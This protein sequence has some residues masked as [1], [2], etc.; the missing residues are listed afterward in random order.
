MNY[1][2]TSRIITLVASIIITFGLYMQVIKIWRTKSAEDFS[3]PLVIAL[4]IN[5][6]AWLNYGLALTEWP[7]IVVGVINVPGVF[8]LG[9]GY[10]KHGRDK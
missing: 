1:L 2:D 3:G 8:L 10:L 9:I 6:L 4:I 5:E 7:I